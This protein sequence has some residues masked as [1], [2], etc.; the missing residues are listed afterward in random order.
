MGLV[1]M[2]TKH[3]KH[4]IAKHLVVGHLYMT[5][6]NAEAKNLLELELDG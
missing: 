1:D 6:G 2:S 5:N 4:D 3:T